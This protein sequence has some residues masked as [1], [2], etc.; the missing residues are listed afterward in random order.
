MMIRKRA[1]KFNAE[2]SYIYIIKNNDLFVGCHFKFKGKLQ[3]CTCV[4]LYVVGFYLRQ[5]LFF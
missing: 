4:V 5:Y 2:C 1:N 3:N